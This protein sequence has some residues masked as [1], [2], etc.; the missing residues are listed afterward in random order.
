MG[1]VACFNSEVLI[2]GGGATGTSIMRDCALRG[3]ACILLDK[4]DIASGTTGRNHGLLHSG[5]RYAVTDSE[6]ARECIQENKI[7]KDIASHCI[8]DTS[9]LFITLPEDDLDFQTT[10]IDACTSAGISTQRLTPQQAIDLEPNVNRSLLSAVKVPDGTL[11]P[12]RLCASN[13]LDAKNHGAKLLTYS[14]VK[15]LIRIGDRIIGAKCIN[16]RTNEQFEVYAQEIINAAGIW[17]KNICHYADLNVQMLPA[18]GSLLVF[19]HRINDLVINRCRKPADADILVPGDSISLIGTTSE[20]I[21][22]KDI[23]ALKISDK[24]VNILI[25]EGAK[26]APILAQTRVL[27]AYAGVR[28]L[29]DISGGD[30]RN[31]SRGIVLLDHQQRDGLAGFSSILGGKLMTCRL[32]AEMTTDLIAGKLGNTSTCTTHLQPLP[33]S[34]VNKHNK[35]KKTVFTTKAATHRH[36]ETAVVTF[37]QSTKGKS[38][39]CECEMVSVGE[40]EYAIKQLDVTNLVDLRRRTRLG[41]GSCQGELCTY[42]A[43]S[44]FCDFANCSGHESSKLLMQFFEE[45]WKGIKPVLFGDA[46]REAEFTYWLYE[47]LFGATDINKLGEK[48]ADKEYYEI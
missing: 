22:Y 42:R 12:F 33:G 24:E 36:G 34:V 30:G 23:D 10:F 38:I 3:I 17:G 43:A 5:A 45:R 20:E 26:L 4:G 35:P 1:K 7:L 21:D 11:D 44:L 18:K 14:M 46:L 9:G 31:I 13:V 6:S 19:E 32:M 40:I 47:G 25:E 28:P 15:S 37:D 2:I 48:Q 29:V 39:V 8:E 27:R 41:M 16:T